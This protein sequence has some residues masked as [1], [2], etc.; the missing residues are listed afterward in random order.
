MKSIGDTLGTIRDIISALPVK[1]EVALVGGYAAI[2]QGV[3]RTTL[4]V[5]VCLY[6]DVLRSA[7]TKE[8]FEVLKRHLPERF[9]AEL[10]EGSK[11]PDDPFKHDLIFLEDS[12]GEYLRIDVLIARYHWELEAIREAEALPGIPLPVLRKPYLVAM[13]LQ[14]TGFKDAGDVVGLVSLMSDADKAKA[15]DLAR[16]TGRDKKLARLL[17]PPA[18][19]VRETSEE[20][21]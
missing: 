7:G 20:L 1:T 14:A 8:F 10:V 3:E 21:L 2:L 6:A 19:E 11:I 16:R 17:A 13:K 9:R 12:K 4:D 5:D 18:E 15:F